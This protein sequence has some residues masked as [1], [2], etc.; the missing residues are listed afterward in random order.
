[1][2]TM[3]HVSA[4]TNDAS[5][6][7]R[8]AEDGTVYVRIGE[9]EH[10]VGQYPEGSAEEA[11][12][13][14]TRRYDAIAF[15][16]H[17]IEQRINSGALSPAEATESLDKISAQLETPNFVGDVA[18]LRGRIGVLRPLIGQQ[19][20]QRRE[21]KARRVAE[22]KEKKAEIV[23]KAEKIAASTDWRHGAQRLRDLMAEW[24]GLARLDKASDDELW[25]RFSAARTAYTK[26]RKVHFAQDNEKREAARQAK[27][28]LIAAAEALSDST[29]WG[30]TS[31][32]YRRLMQDWKNAGMAPRD[33]DEKLWQRFRAAQDKFFSA[34]EAADAEL[35]KEFEANAVV[36]RELL[37]EAEAL[38]PVSDIDAAKRA[39]RDLADKWDAAGKVPRD[40]MKDLE[41]RMR[42][43]EQAIRQAEDQQ[44][45]RSD[46]E[47]SARAN[48][49]VTKL[50]EAIAKLESDVARAESAGDAGKA[51]KLAEELESRRAFLA[52]AEKASA[53]FS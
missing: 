34:R 18:G 22:A 26:A 32:E 39:F 19:K 17:L 16:V 49:M 5:S 37:T 7:G 25:H 8:V 52:M 48:D 21:D 27:E 23:A 42:K 10:S 38:L 50:E 11:M 45:K 24:K 35:D 12:A 2:R 43:V 3:C 36:K 47:K 31:G 46:P 28:K 15:E 1:M 51:T 33:V 41:G 29:D 4:Q 13:F 9:T 53:E 20:V 30:P 44:W 40:Q 6:F 14:F